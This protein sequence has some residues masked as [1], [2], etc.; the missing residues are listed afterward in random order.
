MLLVILLMLLVLLGW[1]HPAAEAEDKT[2]LLPPDCPDG[3]KKIH[4]YPGIDV[5]TLM[6]LK[7]IV[8]YTKFAEDMESV[9][10][11]ILLDKSG[12]KRS[13]KW[14]RYRIILEEEGID[15]KD[16]MLLEEPQQLKGIAVLTWMYLDPDRER[17]N[18]LWL[19]SQRKL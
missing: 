18:W 1:S 17:D 12:L 16:L 2:L 11:F 7:Y 9:G 14:H 15:Y 4:L 8:K 13:R 6:R 10:D 3:C 19:P 5:N